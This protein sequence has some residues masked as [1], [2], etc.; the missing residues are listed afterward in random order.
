MRIL[1]ICD[2]AQLD[3]T[4]DIECI[5]IL[6]DACALDVQLS[7][8]SGGKGTRDRAKNPRWQSPT[9]PGCSRFP[10]LGLI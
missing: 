4:T 1:S 8:G 2:A 7:G 6:V 10:R 9:G 5:Y 3:T